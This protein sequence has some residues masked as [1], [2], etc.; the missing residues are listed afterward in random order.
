MSGYPTRPARAD[1][2][3]TMVDTSPV[4]DASRQLDAARLNLLTWQT[5]G[6]GLMSPLAWI[7]ATFNTTSVVHAHAESWNPDGLTSAPYYTPP[8]ITRLGQGD[9]RIAWPQTVLDKDGVE[10]SLSIMAGI[11]G[12]RSGTL[13]HQAVL[14]GGTIYRVQLRLRDSSGNTGVDNVQALVLVF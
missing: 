10:R 7:F 5:A 12:H 11:V 1:F 4:R 8:Q 6:A 2:G 3:P 13:G 14:D 9:Y